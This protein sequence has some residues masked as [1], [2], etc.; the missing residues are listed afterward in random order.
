VA[1]AAIIYF[2]Q[3]PPAAVVP[4]MANN[5]GA[6]FAGGA[7]AGGPAPDI[8]QMSPRERFDRLFDRIMRAA[9][10]NDSATVVRFTPMGLGA[11]SQLDRYDT[12]ARYH[13]AMLHLNIAEVAEAAALAD[14]IL[15]DTPGHLF[16][17]VIRGEIARRTSKAGDLKRAYADFMAHYDAEMKAG[18]QEYKEHGPVIDEFHRRASSSAGKQ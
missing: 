18:R 12:D 15:K 6:A 8:S 16:G 3:R 10:N 4:D 7:A 5:G 2:V 13:A 14:T 9:E 11:Y 1:L 17:Y